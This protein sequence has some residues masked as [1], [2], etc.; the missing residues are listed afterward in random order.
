MED[1]YSRTGVWWAGGM[2]RVTER[3]HRRVRLLRAHAGA[4]PL[5]VL[6]L[7][8]GFGTTAAVAATGPHPRV[9]A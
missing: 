9:R 8:S 5:R 2:A 1:F 6:E 3:D 4:G 7:G